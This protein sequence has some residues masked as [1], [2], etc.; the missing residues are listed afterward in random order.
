MSAMTDPASRRQ[1][2]IA[3]APIPYYWTREAALGFYRAVAGWPVATVYLGETVCARR[4]EL[5][6]PD[7]LGIAESL[8]L[9]G[10]EVVL[11]TLGLV[12]GEPEMRLVR[13]VAEQGTWLVEANDMN[14]VQLLAGRAPFVAGAAL[15]AYNADTLAL[16]Q[17]AGA[18]RWVAPVEMSGTALSAVLAELAAPIETEVYAHGRAPLAASS[19]CFAAR[20][21]NVSKDHCEYVCLQHPDGI[22]LDTQ[23][24]VALFTLNGTQTQSADETSL[25]AELDDVAA[26]GV[27]LVRIVPRSGSTAEIVAL[28][29]SV[30]SG[31]KP[32]R[33]AWEQA[34]HLG[35]GVRP[36]EFWVPRERRSVD[37]PATPPASAGSPLHSGA[38]P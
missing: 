29:A 36:S 3:L 11:S 27:D 7:W 2:R 8:A 18:R 22:R 30:L 10:K 9:A 17:E 33:E 20:Y 4:R 16:L 12:E 37:T 31:A 14:A 6:L 28:F 21:H 13:A 23:D 15:N 34:E 38:R 26:R 5:R 24:G 19:R 32:Q 25:L 1:P 35:A